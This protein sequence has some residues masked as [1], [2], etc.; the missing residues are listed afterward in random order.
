VKDIQPRLVGESFIIRY[1]DDF[2]LGF[3]HESDAR[4]VLEVLFKRFE[5]YG[6][7]LHPE[8]TKLIVLNNQQDDDT[9][10]FLGFTH[11][12]GNSLKGRPILKRH[13]SKK[14][15]KG[16][17]KK[18][19]QWLRDNRHAYTFEGLIVELNRKLDGYYEYYGITFNSRALQKYFEAIK[20]SLFKWINRRGNQLR[21]NWERYVLRIN[22][23]SPLRKP[24]IRHRFF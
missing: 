14:K 20:R 17:L 10:D 24:T 3:T 22:V 8:K 2:L 19:N 1:A 13:T 15:L 11:Y 7:T 9:F 6:V 4:G 21:L 5:K 23:W 18:L 12:M 16:S